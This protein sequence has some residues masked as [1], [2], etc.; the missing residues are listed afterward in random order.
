MPGF[1]D[2]LPPAVL[3]RDTDRLWLN[4]QTIDPAKIRPG[5]Q[6]YTPTYANLNVGSTGTTVARYHQIGKKVM[7]QWLATLGGTGI[8]VGDVRV[9][10]PVTSVST[11]YVSLVT[12]LGIAHL[13]DSGVALFSGNC[14][15][16]GTTT[17][18]VRYWNMPSGTILRSAVIT[19]TAPFTWAAGDQLSV[20]GAY[21]A[22]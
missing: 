7:F 17:F 16:T 10:L 21:Q 6:D 13:L 5:W 2:P 11:G 19:S 4:S 14:L 18:G 15:W 3:N 22:V 9:S 1:F 12:P 20:V 8:S